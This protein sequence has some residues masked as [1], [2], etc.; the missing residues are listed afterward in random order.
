[1]M[2][3]EQNL[4]EKGEMYYSL[5]RSSTGR[6]EDVVMAV[7]CLHK[8]LRLSQERCLT[9][10]S[11]SNVDLFLLRQAVMLGQ[12]LSYTTLI[13]EGLSF[14]LTARYLA[15]H[16]F[17]G[18]EHGRGFLAKVEY[19]LGGTHERMGALVSARL[20]FEKSVEMTQDVSLKA[21]RAAWLQGLGTRAPSVLVPL[22]VARQHSLMDLCDSLET[23][24]E[25]EETMKED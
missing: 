10:V 6:A 18:T 22:S 5:F 13:E 24:E 1:M 4:M 15:C 12:V 14:L 11:E 21:A 9:N 7:D 2:I 20:S 25:S 8:A 17:A 23:M 16:Y 19:A 3:E